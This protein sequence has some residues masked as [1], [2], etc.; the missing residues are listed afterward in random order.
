MEPDIMAFTET[1]LQDNHQIAYNGYKWL[2]QNRKDQSGGGI[3]MLVK[4]NLCK[5]QVTLHHSHEDIEA[6]WVQIGH[7]NPHCKKMQPK[8]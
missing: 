7:Q 8:C 6:M 3:G 2:A 1:H 4:E 5:T